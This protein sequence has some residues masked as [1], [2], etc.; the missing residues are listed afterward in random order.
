MECNG[1]AKAFLKPNAVICAVAAFTDHIA[2]PTNSL[3]DRANR[4]RKLFDPSHWSSQTQITSP[5]GKL[6]SHTNGRR[7]MLSKT[8]TLELAFKLCLPTCPMNGD[9]PNEC[10]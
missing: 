10:S 1:Y 3:V 2:D 6:M 4:R 7:Q 5:I 8:A 9:V